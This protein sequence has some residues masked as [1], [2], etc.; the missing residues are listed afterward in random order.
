[1]FLNTDVKIGM[2]SERAGCAFCCLLSLSVKNLRVTCSWHL[3]HLSLPED[4]CA[5]AP[6]P[7]SRRF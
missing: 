2:K 1:M 5:Y 4:F 6:V 3:G 7:E